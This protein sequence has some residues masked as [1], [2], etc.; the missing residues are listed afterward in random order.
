MNPPRT[1]NCEELPPEIEE[2][3]EA[4][5]SHSPRRGGGKMRAV[6]TEAVLLATINEVLKIV[7]QTLSKV[8]QI[9]IDRDT[10]WEADTNKTEAGAAG[11][12]L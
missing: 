8:R 7:D 6:T 1:S 2:Q 12:G 9:R 5:R 3:I 4:L 10:I 11:A